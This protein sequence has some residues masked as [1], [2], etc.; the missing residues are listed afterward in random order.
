MLPRRLARPSRIALR[1]VFGAWLVFVGKKSVVCEG[2]NGVSKGT[3]EGRIFR[4]TG[5]SHT[6]WP[7]AEKNRNAALPWRALLRAICARKNAISALQGRQKNGLRIGSIISL[8]SPRR[9]FSPPPRSPAI[10]V[11]Y[12]RSFSVFREA[13]SFQAFGRRR[14]L[15]LEL[16]RASVW[17]SNGAFL[18]GEVRLTTR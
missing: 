4:M 16:L 15:S 3:T 11:C 9:V 14:G 12:D 6:R 18:A 17:C 10:A 7:P 1:D 5:R 2:R 8:A 13:A